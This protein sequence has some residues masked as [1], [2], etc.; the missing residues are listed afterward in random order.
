[1]KK[2]LLYFHGK[3]GSA[4]EAEHLRPLFPAY[5][6]FGFDYHAT[7]PW[8]AQEEFG[9]CYDEFSAAHDAVAVVANSLGAYFSL[10][11]LSDKNIEKACFIS[12][13]VNMEKLICDLMSLSGVTEDELQKRGTIE[14]PLGEP[15]S[16]EYLTWVRCHP[17]VWNTP[18]AILYG[19]NDTLQ[20]IDTIRGFADACG[21]SVTVLKNAEHWIH[22]AE[23]IAFLDRW[24]K[25]E[26]H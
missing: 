13:V 16:W 4:E 14:T 21:A 23:E 19:E 24:I 25:A 12:P 8:E 20:S 7:K 3:G 5:D 22:T 26:I 6:V 18:T 11:A 10:N 9:R 2:G 1:M 17:I 15:L